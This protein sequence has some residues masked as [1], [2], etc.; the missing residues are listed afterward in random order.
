M[1]G[2]IFFDLARA[3]DS[4]N[5][6]LLIQ[7]LPHYGI[8]GK[9]KLLLESYITNRFQRVQLDSST[10]NL[11]TTSTW[12]KVKHG[13]PQGSVLGPLLFLLYINDLPNAIIQYVT[14]ILFANDTSIII[15]G[16]DPHKVQD[17]LNTTFRQISEWF[18]LN[19]LSLNISKTHFIQLSSK[20]LNDSDIN[21]IYENNYISKVNDLNFSG[22]N[23]NNTL[24]WKTHKD[25]I[26]PKL[27]SACFAM[28]AVKLFM[29]P[30]ILKAIYYSYFHSIILYGVIF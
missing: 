17:N 12:N 13:V 28:W 26:L 5:H 23:I 10:L 3:F 8:I 15:T 1:V 19:S 22:L 27:S 25:K 16:R 20:S 29:P 9:S 11:K 4:I 7:K 24:S 30:Q 18:Q 6:L 14:P 2:S 21:I